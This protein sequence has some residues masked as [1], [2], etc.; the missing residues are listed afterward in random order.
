MGR[1]GESLSGAWSPF[2]AMGLRGD[3]VGPYNRSRAKMDANSYTLFG[4]KPLQDDVAYQV[5]PDHGRP[6]SRAEFPEQMI[7]AC[8]PAG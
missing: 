2:T 4:R 5:F 7:D 6:R 3:P 8:I 1:L